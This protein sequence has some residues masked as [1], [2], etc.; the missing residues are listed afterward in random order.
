MHFQQEGTHALTW[1]NSEYVELVKPVVM[2]PSLRTLRASRFDNASDEDLHDYCHFVRDSAVKVS[3]DVD[4]RVEKETR[5]QHKS[6][7]GT[8]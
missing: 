3:K 5:E 6:H 8:Q 7:H 4:H 2:P 1:R